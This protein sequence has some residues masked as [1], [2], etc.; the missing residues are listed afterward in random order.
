MVTISCSSDVLFEC[1]FK[2]QA[3]VRTEHPIVARRRTEHLFSL[4]HNDSPCECQ[5][6]VRAL[7]RN[8]YEHQSDIHVYVSRTSSYIPV[9]HL[10]AT[11]APYLCNITTK[12][13]PFCNT[14]TMC[15]TPIVIDTCGLCDLEYTWPVGS[16]KPT[17]KDRCE[18]YRQG[19][20]CETTGTREAERRVEPCTKCMKDPGKRILPH[21]AYALRK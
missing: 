10:I 15:T 19:K 5:V 11:Q 14:A 8:H 3:I 1:T 16:F 18:N 7:Q 9:P 20:K 21:R 2:C 4:F 6:V 12:Q 17:K 13:S